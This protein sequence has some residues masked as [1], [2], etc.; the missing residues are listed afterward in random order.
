M[1]RKVKVAKKIQLKRLNELKKLYL[2]EMER[3]EKR[4]KKWYWKTKLPIE[5]K[6]GIPWKKDNKKKEFFL[7]SAIFIYI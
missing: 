4:R 7:K 6:W 5:N 1:E 3:I 2:E